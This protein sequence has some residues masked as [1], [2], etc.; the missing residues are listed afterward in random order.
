MDGAL[1]NLVLLV[2][3]IVGCVLFA[4]GLALLTLSS[5]LL[6]HIRDDL[7]ELLEIQRKA[8]WA[9]PPEA[10]PAP[11]PLENSTAAPSFRLLS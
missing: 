11:P 1:V 4:F 9:Q 10:S 2:I 8:P 6:G 3:A 7:G 5:Y